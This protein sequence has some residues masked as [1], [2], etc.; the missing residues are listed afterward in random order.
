MNFS[1]TQHDRRI[2]PGTTGTVRIFLHFQSPYLP[3]PAC[4]R[5]YAPLAV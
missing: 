1:I 5:W 3:H 2:V 4:Q